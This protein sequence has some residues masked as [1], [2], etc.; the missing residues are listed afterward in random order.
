MATEPQ[1]EA[2]KPHGVATKAGAWV[3]VAMLVL[4]LGGFGVTNFGGTLTSIG[5]VGDRSLTVTDYAQSLQQEV[6]DFSQRVGQQITTQQAIAFGLDKQAL[7][8]LI[9][10]AALDNEADRI[11]LSVG[12]RRVAAEI[13][14]M[15]AF[16]GTAGGFDRETYRFAL[17]RAN[18]SEPEFED[19]MRRDLARSVLQGAVAGG[20]AAPAPLTDT[21]YAYVGERRGFSLL[22]LTEA[23]LATPLADPTEA[24]LTAFY[25]ENTAN[26]FTRPEARRITYVA[27]LPDDIAKDQVID[28]AAL[29]KLYDAR[30]TEFVVPERRLVERLIYPSQADATAAKARLDAGTPFET[31][32][33]ER[34]LAL[35]D[36]DLGDVA[37]A[38]LGEAGA[39]VF[40]LTEP[41]VTG[42]LPSDL[43]PAL[44]RMNAV[45]ATQNTSFDDAKATLATEAQSEAARKVIADK[46]EAIDDLLASGAA[47]ADLQS[48]MGMT[49]GTIDYVPGAEAPDAIAAYPAFREAADAVAAGDFPQAIT[50][51]DGGIVALQLDEML[52]PAPIPF[53]DAKDDVTSA[54]RDAALTRA[55]SARAAEAMAAIKGGASLGAYGIVETTPQIAR[56]GTVAGAPADVLTAVFQMAP[57]DLRVIEAPGFTA[58]VRLDSITPAASTGDD[59]AALKGALA[60]QIEQALSAD[61]LTAFTEALTAE[62][63]ISLDQSALNA[64]NAQFQ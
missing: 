6:A 56:D 47:L 55:L 34:G 48:E 3:I 29:R 7:Q 13:T 41:G 10:R 27:L 62:A 22:R 21:L 32:V 59:A 18:L 23:D 2:R 57:G 35:S 30:I 46:L 42:P 12:D 15:P 1:T 16:Q 26:L 4:G 45:L 53:A 51:D 58:L 49:L 28:E 25:T 5:T 24:E 63:G 36:V 44:Y 40:A 39:A 33:S 11:G 8:G 19:T 9:T 50:L 43:G 64:V 38:D 37:Q 14:R 61:A 20:F 54:W 31:L 60:G 52:P 17:D